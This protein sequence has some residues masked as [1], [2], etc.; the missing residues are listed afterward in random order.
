MNSF[1]PMMLVI[2]II[3]M[4]DNELIARFMGLNIT[5]WKEITQPYYKGECFSADRPNR[6]WGCGASSK[7]EVLESLLR[8]SDKYHTSWDWLM[9]VVE[10]IAEMG[11]SGYEDNNIE[12]VEQGGKVAGLQVCMGIERVY[13]AVVEFIKWYN[14]QS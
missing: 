3:V 7:K 10:K 13:Q 6:P 2:K 8:A 4:T 1:T 5:E 11:M 14:Q 9:P 12:L